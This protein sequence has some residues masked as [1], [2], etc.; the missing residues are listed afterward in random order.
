MPG[1]WSMRVQD[2][3]EVLASQ[4]GGD[5]SRLVSDMIGVLAASSPSAVGFIVN[6]DGI[7]KPYF[8]WEADG[9]AWREAPHF[10]VVG[11]T[12]ARWK[13]VV[14]HRGNSLA[15]TIPA[16]TAR[17]LELDD[18]CEVEVEVRLP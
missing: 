15:I 10:H 3:S 13:A 2:G 8:Q 16:D 7:E 17:T 11:P 9:L 4:V 18:G 1:V 6:P 12:V 14:R 5:P